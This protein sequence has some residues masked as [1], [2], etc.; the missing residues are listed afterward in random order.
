LCFIIAAI[1]I[2]LLLGIKY[3]EVKWIKSWI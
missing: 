2:A 1:M 3:F